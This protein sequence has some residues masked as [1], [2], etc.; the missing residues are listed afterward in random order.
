MILLNHLCIQ[1]TINIFSNSEVLSESSTT[2]RDKITL[3]IPLHHSDQ[4]F[5]V[6]QR[7]VVDRRVKLSLIKRDVD[8]HSE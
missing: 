6:T 4:G 8:F 1:D 2:L 3:N 7:L 5:P